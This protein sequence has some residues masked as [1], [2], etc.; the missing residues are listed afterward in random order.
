MKNGNN[1]YILTSDGK[2]ISEDELYHALSIRSWKESKNHKYISREW[3]K[4]GWVYKYP[5]D[6]NTKSTSKTNAQTQTKTGTDL[7]NTLSSYFKSASSTMNKTASTKSTGVK[8][9]AST[10]LKALTNASSKPTANASKSN[11]PSD[12]SKSIANNILNKLG[13][14]DISNVK[15]GSTPNKENASESKIGSLI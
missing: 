15:V 2:F 11:K 10:G 7:L 12:Y 5:S 6:S 13:K 1:N 4:S 3:G 8:N 14:T 9:L